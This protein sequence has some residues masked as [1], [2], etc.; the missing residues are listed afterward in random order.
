MLAKDFDA[1]A[2]GIASRLKLALSWRNGTMQNRCSL[3]KNADSVH[4]V[5]FNGSQEKQMVRLKTRNTWKARRVL[6]PNKSKLV[7]TLSFELPET[8]SPYIL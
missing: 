1:I 7:F 3:R 2:V 5:P 6:R 8:V 4:E